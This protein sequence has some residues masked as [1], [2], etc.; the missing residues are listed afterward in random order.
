MENC[1]GEYMSNEESQLDQ[2]FQ[3]Y[4]AACPDVEPGADFMPR[5][6]QAIEARR[7]F[8][9]AF[10]HW[11]RTAMAACTAVCLLLLVLNFVLP[12]QARPTD[13]KSVV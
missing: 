7:G 8:W 13:R 12:A 2:L 5:L 10:E 6:W 4:R 11:A 9:F 3:S 1:S